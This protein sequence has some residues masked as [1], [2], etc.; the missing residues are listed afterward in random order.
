MHLI[1][2]LFILQSFFVSN[3][4][5]CIIYLRNCVLFK[6]PSLSNICI[7]YMYLFQDYNIEIN[8][9]S[10]VHIFITIEYIQHVPKKT[11]RG[12]GWY[13]PK[14][15]LNLKNSCISTALKK[16]ISILSSIAKKLQARHFLQKSLSE[17][18]PGL[19]RTAY[20][21]QGMFM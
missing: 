1:S 8:I 21:S 2:W 15:L 7:L 5:S 6:V 19:K 3:I 17:K 13:F 10:E 14:L 9:I 12:T 20:S 4:Y 16:E 11:L 18:A